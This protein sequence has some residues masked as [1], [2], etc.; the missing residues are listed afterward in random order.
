[1]LLGHPGSD[2][3]EG[4]LAGA[5]HTAEVPMGYRCR[6]FEVEGDR[7]PGE[8]PMCLSDPDQVIPR[9]RMCGVLQQNL[10]SDRAA[11]VSAAGYNR[12]QGKRW[13]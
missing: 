6:D 4:V 1:M 3:I 2:L 8:G 11:T 10:P 9:P 7:R 5:V 12:R 13:C